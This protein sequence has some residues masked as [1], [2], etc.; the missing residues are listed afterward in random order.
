MIYPHPKNKPRRFNLNT[1]GG[2]KAWLRLKDEVWSRDRGVCQL[3]YMNAV[4]PEYH[5]A[6]F[7]SQGGEDRLNNVLILCHDCHIAGNID[8]PHVGIHSGN[9]G[10]QETRELAVKRMEAINA[11]GLL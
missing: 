11:K 9:K 8:C 1:R 7:K 6:I 3:C 10:A 2:R 4:V 5:H